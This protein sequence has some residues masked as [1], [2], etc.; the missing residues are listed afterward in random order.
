MLKIYFKNIFR[1]TQKIINKRFKNFIEPQSRLGMY[2]YQSYFFEELQ[3]YDAQIL[4]EEYNKW[5]NKKLEEGEKDMKEGRFCSLEE[6]RQK[7]MKKEE[8][9]KELIKKGG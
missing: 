4:K 7:R 3:P 1:L 6:F 8:E 5:L 2:G 9:I